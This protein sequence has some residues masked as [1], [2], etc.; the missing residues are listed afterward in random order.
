MDI[1][2]QNSSGM[3][4]G[5]PPTIKEEKKIGPIIGTLIIVIL[6]IIGALYFFGKRLDNKQQ[7]DSQKLQGL[8]NRYIPARNDTV[9]TDT[10]TSVDESTLESDL[11]SQL[12]DIDSS[13]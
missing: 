13:F 11:D 10:S 3:M 2:T 5:M 1:N 9:N 12:K 6:I 4:N 8:E 7:Y